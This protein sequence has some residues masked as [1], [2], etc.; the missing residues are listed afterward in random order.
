MCIRDSLNGHMNNT[1]YGELVSNALENRL[2][3]GEQIKDIDI[4]YHKEVL[5]GEQIN[6]Y[7]L[8]DNKKFY[9]KGVVNDKNCFEACGSMV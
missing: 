3:A 5:F 9:I 7:M 1:V 4:F 6:L 2:N 8:E